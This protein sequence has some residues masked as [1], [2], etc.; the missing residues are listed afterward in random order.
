MTLTIPTPVFA[1][2]QANQVA[3]INTGDLISAQPM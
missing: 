3:Q 1:Q 2:D